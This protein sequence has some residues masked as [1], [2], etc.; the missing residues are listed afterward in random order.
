MSPDTLQWFEQSSLGQWARETSWLFLAA[1]TA[2][3]MGLSVLLGSLAV[4]DARILGFMRQAP[5]E[6]LVGV[7]PFAIAGFLI[8]LASGFVMFCADAARYWSNPWFKFKLLLVIAAGLNALWFWLAEQ[9]DVE[10]LKSGQ[11]AATSAK[12]VAA[13][14]LMLWLAVLTIGRLLPYVEEAI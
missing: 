14:S 5:G 9:A 8:N 7:I 13:A 6:R 10:S 11:D 3:F 12:L 1:E 4:L 2:H